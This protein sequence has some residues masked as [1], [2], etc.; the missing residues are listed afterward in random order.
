LVHEGGLERSV[1]DRARHGVAPHRRP[2]RSADEHL[3]RWV[4][5][6]P[7]STTGHAEV[8]HEGRVLDSDD[9]PLAASLDRLH[10]VVGN[11]PC[12]ARCDRRCASSQGR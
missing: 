9:Q 6:R 1:D 12:R 10:V 8:D 11:G 4:R 5:P 7:A 2:S 3:D